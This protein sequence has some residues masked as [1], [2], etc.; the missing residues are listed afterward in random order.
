MG[1]ELFVRLKRLAA[2]RGDE[3]AV[4]VIGDGVASGAG[5]TWR[6]LHDAVGRVV[7]KL[8]GD[9]AFPAGGSVMLRSGNRPEMAA[10]FLGVIAS[11]RRLL[12]V[13]PALTGHEVSKLAERSG[14]GVL[15]EDSSSAL[16][17][18]DE[19]IVRREIV[20]LCAGEDA[21]PW[22]DRGGSGWL[23]LQSS[24]TTGGPKMVRRDGRSLDAVARNVAEAAG[25]RADDRVLAAVPLS[26]SYGIENGLLAPLWAGA[27]MLHVAAAPGQVG[28]G[29]DPR[30]AVDGEATVLPGVPAI[31]EMI[32]RLELGRGGLRL[33]YS[34]GA[35]LP[36][37]LAERFEARLGL[38]LGQLYGSTEIGSVTFG[39]EPDTV[40]W[41]MAGVEVRILDPD[42]PDPGNPLPVGTAGHV[43][44]KAPSMFAGYVQD[45]AEARASI[46]DGYFLTGDLGRLDDQ[47]RLVITGRL[48]LLIDVGGVKVNPLEV[49][50]A[51]VQYPGVGA[52]VVLPDPASPTV[53]RVKAFLE[54][55]ADAPPLD[56]M[57]LRRFLRQR[58]A[59]HKIPRTFECRAALP[60]SP[61]GKILR[62]KL[63][64]PQVTA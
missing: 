51:I 43:A 33:A 8:D 45:S 38:K 34:A 48:K 54:M 37:E 11:G 52:C 3:A 29:F 24:G 9:R 41:P 1:L 21:G 63:M 46:V 4:R 31:F 23:L 42:R 35:T 13:D 62:Q 25:I 64:Q 6:S 47:G 59:G 44:V 57:A 58:L 17:G 50:Q 60:K 12:P 7:R 2:D 16:A 28:R 14:A 61:T 15:I 30:W 10:V 26:H 40:G 19:G 22:E 32:D 5:M 27:C 18:L 20:G 49:E 39:N 53:S 36:T 56:E 55:Q